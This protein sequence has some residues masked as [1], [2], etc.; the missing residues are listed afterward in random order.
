MA[1]IRDIDPSNEAEIILVA[2]RMRA[3]LME[4]V[5]AEEGEAM[6]SMDWLVDRVKFHL[7]PGRCTGRVILAEL[8]TEIA[9][10]CILR[11]EKDEDGAEFGLFSTFYVAPERRRRRIADRF[12]DLGEE[13]FKSLGLGCARTYTAETNDPLHRLMESHGYVIELRK[14][15]MVSFMKPI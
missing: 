2:E 11:V 12:V 8:G 4:V 6:Y 14:N 15:E 1:R 5:G 10:H 9:G 13:W 3:T 7:D